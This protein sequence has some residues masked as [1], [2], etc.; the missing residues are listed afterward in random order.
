MNA[1]KYLLQAAYE[2]CRLRP[3]E[4]IT[5]KEICEEAEVSKQT[6]YRYYKDKYELVNELYRQLTQA[7]I[8]DANAVTTMDDWKQMYLTQFRA[9][10]EHLEVVRHLYSS[11]ETGCTLQYEIE[12]T[13][14]FDR[15]LLASKGADLTKSADSI[16]HRSQGCRRYIHDEGLDSRRHAGR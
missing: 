11:R 15:L 4:R 8:I 9:F 6:V 1:K 7:S 5:L 12:S 13:I 2:L 14:R 10:R 3:I 16:R